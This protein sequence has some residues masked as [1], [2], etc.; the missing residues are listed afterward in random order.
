MKVIRPL[1]KLEIKQLNE[2][3]LADFPSTRFIINEPHNNLNKSKYYE[4]VTYRYKVV[5]GTPINFYPS[6][7][8]KNGLIERNK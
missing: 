7:E 6:Y 1:T 3:L 5:Y 4:Y 2:L 8:I